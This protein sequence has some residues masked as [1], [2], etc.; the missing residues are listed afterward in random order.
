M[1]DIS[2]LRSEDI[3]LEEGVGNICYLKSEDKTT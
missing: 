2:Y 1:I 3:I